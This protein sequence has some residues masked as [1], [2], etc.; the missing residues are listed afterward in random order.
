MV[1]ESGRAKDK[2]RE[3]YGEISFIRWLLTLRKLHGLSHREIARQL[4]IS[5]NTVNVHAA[6]GVLRC[7]EYLRTKG[8]EGRR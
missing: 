7:R 8:L 5:E 6:L 4:G 3:A 2:R 1:R